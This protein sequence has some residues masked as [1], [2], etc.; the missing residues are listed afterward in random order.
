MI[1]AGPFE[2]RT[3]LFQVHSKLTGKGHRTLKTGFLWGITLPPLPPP[4]L[5][6]LHICQLQPPGKMRRRLLSHLQQFDILK[7]PDKAVRTAVA[8][9]SVGLIFIVR[10]ETQVGA[11]PTASLKSGLPVA[12]PL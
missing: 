12:S 11:T 5:S 1:L 8:V 4:L 10:D 9:R 6:T 2:V 7:I 3:L